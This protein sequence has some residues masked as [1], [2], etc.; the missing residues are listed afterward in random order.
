MLTLLIHG[1]VLRS[2]YV[3]HGPETVVLTHGLM[4]GSANFAA[5]R[6]SLGDRYRAVTLVVRGK[7]CSEKSPE[8]L[9][10]DSLAEGKVAPA[11]RL[12]LNSVPH[13][14]P[15]IGTS[16]A[17][18]VA[19]K[20]SAPVRLVRPVRPESAIAVRERIAGSTFLPFTRIAH[21]VV[22]E[23]TAEFSRTFGAFVQRA[24]AVA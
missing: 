9:D 8:R 19:A 22:F 12:E 16:I 24:G 2:D 5:Q 6:E 1:A 18:R 15:S 3:G 21:A 14:G 17:R 7:A 10:F 13:A 4:L 23:R 11:Q 20:P